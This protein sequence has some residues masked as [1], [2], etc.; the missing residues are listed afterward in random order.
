MTPRGEGLTIL[1]DR[2]R[3]GVGGG[4]GRAG[5]KAREL[6]KGDQGQ[7]GGIV[8]RQELAVDRKHGRSGSIEPTQ[9]GMIAG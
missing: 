7:T 5:W 3:R 8:E 1:Y 6:V 9:A 4:G 2:R